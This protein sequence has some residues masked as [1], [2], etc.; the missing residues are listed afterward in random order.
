M[1]EVW[2]DNTSEKEIKDQAGQKTSWIVKD[3]LY[4]SGKT[5]DSTDFDWIT[6]DNIGFDVVASL[7]KL[8]FMDGM[9]ENYEALI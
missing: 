6:G 9:N 5:T 1:L 3:E 7:L 2:Y 8:F 4:P